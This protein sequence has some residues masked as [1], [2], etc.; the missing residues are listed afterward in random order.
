MMV[1]VLIYTFIPPMSLI[2]MGQLGTKYLDAIGL[3]NTIMN[4]S[5]VSVVSGLSVACDTVFSQSFGS[6]NK[7]MVGVYLQRSFVVIG[8]F[9]FPCLFIHLNAETLLRLMGQDP[10]IARIAGTYCIYLIPFVPCVFVY[11][12]LGKYLRNQNII[13]PYI[14][15][16]AIGLAVNILLHYLLVTVA[17][18]GVLGSAIAQD[19]SFFVLA[20]TTFLYIMISKLYVVT[21]G[22]FT[23][24]AFHDWGPFMVLSVAGLA[25]ICLQW[26]AYEIGTLLTGLL[27]EV[28]LGAQAILFQ[29]ELFM[30]AI[31]YSVGIAC[32][33]RVGQLLGANN[34]WLARRSLVLGYMMVWTLGL[35]A[36]ILLLSC[37]D[38]IPRIFS[39][40]EEVIKTTSDIIPI[41]AL[42][43]IFDGTTGT[44]SGIMR[45][46]G[47]QNIAA[48]IIFVGI[49]MIGLPIGLSLMFL[50]DLKS[51][52]FWWG[53]TIGLFIEAIVYIIAVF[54]TDWEGEAEAAQHRAG[55]YQN[56]D[57]D[58]A[59][60]TSSK[61]E[62][63]K[64]ALIERPH[65]KQLSNA[66]KKLYCGE[67]VSSQPNIYLSSKTLQASEKLS[68]RELIF[69]RVI[70]FLVFFSVFLIGLFCHFHF[71]NTIVTTFSE[72]C[73]PYNTTWQPENI[74]MTD[75]ISGNLSMPICNSTTDVNRGVSRAIQPLHF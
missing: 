66:S 64:T 75:V 69:R 51:A 56:K 38:V 46:C 17:E 29:I 8:I 52:G 4:I 58:A 34:P 16:S 5:G 43:H 35:I 28:Q 9:L 60:F 39:A 25:M 10:E 2:F 6:P 20:L 18:L 30:Y 70:T 65:S 71:S 54:K 11:S 57:G 37:K 73:L 7:K 22:G 1:V 3:G 49:Y 19:C 23:S 50:T 27:G 61:D 42:Y 36:I 68:T 14:W 21:W 72:L 41:L 33:I 48:F 15:I 13:F 44:S 63:D 53:L 45:G 67:Y 62:S 26:W 47:R 12:V 40:D 59:D 55:L 24:E 74:N 31:P 32:N